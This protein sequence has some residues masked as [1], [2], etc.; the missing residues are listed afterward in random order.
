MRIT[1]F[2]ASVATLACLMVTS[3]FAADVDGKWTA[4]MPGRQGNTQEVT[5]NFKA[6][7]SKLT[8]T[9]ANA[10][11]ETE[12]KDGKIDGDK[13]TFSQTFE[14][15]GNSMTF[16]YKGK[17]SGDSIEFT[18]EMQGGD[19]PAQKFTAKKAN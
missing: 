8:G 1:A 16:V 2:L 15:G 11:G 6:D 10:R 19:R 7:G 4:S 12:I 5:F 9:M 17:V 18:R 13:V 14:R 3:A